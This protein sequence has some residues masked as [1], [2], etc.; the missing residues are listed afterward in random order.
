[1]KTRKNR[2]SVIAVLAVLLVAA[3][4]IGSTLAFLTDNDEVVNTFTIGDI[5]IELDEP[6]WDEPEDIFPGQ[7]YAK[8]PTIE[9]LEGEMFARMIVEYRDVR[10]GELITCQDRIALI[11]STMFYDPA[12]VNG[13]RNPDF[14]PEE[15]FCAI[16]NNPW[17]TAPGGAGL[18][19]PVIPV[20]SPAT[21]M[22]GFLDSEDLDDLVDDGDVYRVYNPHQ[23]V[24]DAGR[25]NLAAGF[26]VFNFFNEDSTPMED[27]LRAGTPNDT[28]VLFTTVAFPSDWNQVQMRMIRGDHYVDEWCDDEEEYEQVRVRGEG[29]QI[30][31]RA[32]AIQIAGFA[33]SA[34]A[35]TALDGTPGTMMPTTTP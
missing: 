14:D 28:A 25:S 17:I 27:I 5:E 30:V 21:A 23:F 34:A 7:A 24:R 11:R 4:A 1:M 12:F 16:D 9:A 22:P 29:F 10:T 13:T 31:V 35:F 33:D 6:D 8:N 32:E 2:K 18:S 15:D 26:E 3:I 20:T 19:I